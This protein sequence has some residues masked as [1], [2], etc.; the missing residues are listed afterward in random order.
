MTLDKRPDTIK[1]IKEIKK[2]LSYTL[3]VY[4]RSLIYH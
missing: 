1:V 4:N 2:S 3:K